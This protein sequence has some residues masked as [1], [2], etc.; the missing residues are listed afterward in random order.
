[1]FPLWFITNTAMKVIMAF[2][3]DPNSFLY[4]K[5][6]FQHTF[7]SI[8][9]NFIILMSFLSYCEFRI[10]SLVYFPTY[11]IACLLVSYAENAAVYEAR[12]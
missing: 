9:E 2:T 4:N 5:A 11:M 6:E 8:T 12:L 3:T 7:I 1:V 10:S